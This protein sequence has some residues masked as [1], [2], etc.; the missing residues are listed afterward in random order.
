MPQ[1]FQRE[2]VRLIHRLLPMLSEVHSAP[3]DQVR[4]LEAI[5]SEGMIVFR[6]TIGGQPFERTIDTR[7]APVLDPREWIKRE[8]LSV[9]DAVWATANRL[10]KFNDPSVPGLSY[11]PA[12]DSF[13]AYS[14]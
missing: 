14:A 11:I 9:M 1:E 8:V 13:S 3:G 6:A 10:G 2:T 5:E 7:L 12:T 4:D